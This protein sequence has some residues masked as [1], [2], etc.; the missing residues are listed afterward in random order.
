VL[1][2]ETTQCCSVGSQQDLIEKL[3]IIDSR[4]HRIPMLVTKCMSVLFIV[5]T[6]CVLK[7]IMTSLTDIGYDSDLE[8][9]N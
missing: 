9:L 4:S 3:L 8:E 7:D 5:Q 1:N 2:E 6:D